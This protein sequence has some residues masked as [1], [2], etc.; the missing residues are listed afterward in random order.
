MEKAITWIEQNEADIADLI[1]D[2]LGG[3]RLKAT[4]EIYLVKCLIKEASTYLLM[5]SRNA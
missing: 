4:I 2:E 5:E 3:T 1:I